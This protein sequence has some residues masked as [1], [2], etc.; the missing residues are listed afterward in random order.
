M[1]T[2]IILFFLIFFSSF[3]LAQIADFNAS[4]PYVWDTPFAMFG[5]YT[6][7]NGDQNILCHFFVYDL[8]GMLVYRFTSEYV[9]PQ[10]TFSNTPIALKSPPFYR[11]IDYNAVTVCASSIKSQRFSVVQRGTIE[12][13]AF[14]EYSWLLSPDNL[15]PAAILIGIAAI[16]WIGY[17]VARRK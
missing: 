15:F 9:T 4:N 5:H 2:K 11:G 17:N 3:G 6:N 8:N 12:N 16:A 14:Y 7:P 13:A 1:N 10:G